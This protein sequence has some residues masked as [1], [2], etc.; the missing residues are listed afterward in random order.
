[1]AKA[2]NLRQQIPVR[3]G[4]QSTSPNKPNVLDSLMTPRLRLGSVTKSDYPAIASL[5]SNPAVQRFLCLSKAP[6][7]YEEALADLPCFL[8]IPAPPGG[9]IWCICNRSTTDFLGLILLL[10]AENYSKIELGYRLLPKFWNHGY[11]TEAGCA[12]VN[13]AFTN[14]G[15]TELCAIIHPD[16]TASKTVAEKLG[17]LRIDCTTRL[18]FNLDHYTLMRDSLIS[19]DSQKAATN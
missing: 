15:L 14:L 8:S 3:A 13:Y 7:T 10:Y 9:G 5:N 18:G 11:V 6:P 12:V 16:N 17:F 2:E 1:M 19:S 4:A